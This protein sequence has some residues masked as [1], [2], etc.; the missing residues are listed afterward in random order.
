MFHKVQN[1]WSPQ[2]TIQKFT[3]TPSISAEVLSLAAELQRWWK[4][5]N[6]W[7]PE[8]SPECRITNL[9]WF[10]LL[11]F[12]PVSF[13]G[14]NFFSICP[15]VFLDCSH[16][17]GD[18]MTRLNRKSGQNLQ[19]DVSRWV[20]NEE[21]VNLFVVVS[22]LLFYIKVLLFVLDNKMFCVALPVLCV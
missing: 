11:P 15:L 22:F 8:S 9:T 16:I 13:T 21:M 1:L 18:A 6:V 10:C 4:P 19:T 7:I 12:T 20:L 3:F 2:I 17:N 5:E 14:L